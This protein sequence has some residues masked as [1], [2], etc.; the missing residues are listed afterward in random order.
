MKRSTALPESGAPEL[1]IPD[2]E[3]ITTN[4]EC[5]N[6]MGTL[7]CSIA[8]KPACILEGKKAD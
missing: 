3:V 8:G 7:P 4:F 5:T 2:D 1:S 6:W